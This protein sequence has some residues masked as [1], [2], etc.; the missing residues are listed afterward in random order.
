MADKRT[1]PRLFV[2]EPLVADR[3]LDLSAK[4]AHYVCN[5]MRRG[6]GDSLLLFNGHDGEWRADIVTSGRG[7]T[8]RPTDRTRPQAEEP[9]LWLVFERKLGL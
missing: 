3:S 8:V 7:C 1:G 5:V 4:Q 2:E 9:D 6:V